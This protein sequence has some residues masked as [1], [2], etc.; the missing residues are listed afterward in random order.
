[1][2]NAILLNCT[3]TYSHVGCYLT[4]SGLKKLLIECGVN[5][6][7]EHEVNNYDFS[8]V[9]S[10]LESNVDTVLLING[11]G[12]I[13]DDQD[14]AKALLDI[15][16]DYSQRTL[17]LNSQL[18]NMSQK[19][20]DII[21]TLKFVQVRTKFDHDWC[22]E[23]G[24]SDIVYCPDMLFYSGILPTLSIASE[25][26]LYSDSH[27]D[28]AS[29][30]LFNCY[31]KRDK[32]K[33]WVN[34]HYSPVGTHVNQIKRVML[35]ILSKFFSKRFGY[36]KENYYAQASLSN[37][38][39]DFCMSKAIVT[40][41][42]HGA[43]LAIALGKPLL[44]SYSNTSKIKDLCRDFEY[45]V[46]L[47]VSSIVNDDNISRQAL[48]IDNYKIKKYLNLHYI[49]LKEKVIDIVK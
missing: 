39:Q 5:I 40:G 22:K 15:A 27:D 10:L 20:V 19:Y 13:H 23:N 1:M 18:R 49:N 33:T 8:F 26:I 7:H 29:N 37:I 36:R 47:N 46:E 6:I 25:R 24:I 42:Y 31:A 11:E 34:M 30:E 38:L 14:Y 48:N 9:V 4:I 35:K 21:K 3:S 17:L 41:R 32:F 43:C 45:G 44:Y 16:A 2:K 28:K 12:T